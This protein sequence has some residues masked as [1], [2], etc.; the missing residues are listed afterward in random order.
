MWAVFWI[1]RCGYTSYRVSFWISNPSSCGGGKVA[2][3]PGVE[4]ISIAYVPTKL[5]KTI[6]VILLTS[7]DDRKIPEVYAGSLTI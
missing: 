4:D 7:S 1:F 5:M 6:L 3:T 2:I